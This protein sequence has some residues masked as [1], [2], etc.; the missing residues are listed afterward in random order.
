MK[1][2]IIPLLVGLLIILA[3][4]CT[5]YKGERIETGGP[6]KV[7][8]R[9]L[10][11]DL[12]QVRLLDG[13]FKHATELNIESLLNYEPDRFLAT[14]RLEA[15]LEPK[16]E[17]YGGWEDYPRRNLNGHS[18]GHYM[19]ALTLMY[20]TTGDKQFL[21]RLNYIVDELAICQEAS[22]DGYLGALPDA[23]KVF[24]E[25]VARGDIRSAGFDLN[26]Y[27]APFYIIHKIIT[28]IPQ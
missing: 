15:G 7:D 2:F 24:E 13:R 4:S 28:I 21:D 26:G 27:W 6:E 19:T 16:A 11:F 22:G 5:D 10:P 17:H 3:D 14:F 8:F 9:V 1:N 23:K 25:E 20:Q 12:S 18:I